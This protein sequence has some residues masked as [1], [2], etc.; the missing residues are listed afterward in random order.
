MFTVDEDKQVKKQ[1]RIPGGKK[2]VTMVLGCTGLFQETMEP[3]NMVMKALDILVI[4]GL[5]VPK[6][7]VT[8]E[9]SVEKT[10]KQCRKLL[11]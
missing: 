11:I 1:S 6:L 4:E 5:I 8:N 7:G 2:A 10:R 9:D 3:T